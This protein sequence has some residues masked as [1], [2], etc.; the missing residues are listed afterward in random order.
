MKKILVV[1]DEKDFCTLV[2]DILERDGYQ[3][4]TCSDSKIAFMEIMSCMPDLILLDLKM[5]GISG[6]EIASELTRH[7]ETREIPIAF[8]TVIV[9]EKE[10]ANYN[11]ITRDRTI[12][13]KPLD[14]PKLRHGVKMILGG[15]TCVA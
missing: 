6:N 2:K 15:G 3:V 5:P 1:D 14:I 9:N 12:F 13:S 10:A 8:I 7:K 11:K 4:Y